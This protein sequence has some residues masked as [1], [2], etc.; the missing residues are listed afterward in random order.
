MVAIAASDILWKY[1]VTTGS[2]GNSTAG[3]QAGSLGKYISTTTITD[4][5]LNNWTGD[6]TASENAAGT[7]KYRCFFVLNNHATDAWNAPGVYISAQTASGVD[8][9][10]SVDTTGATAKAS[11]S[12]QAKTI[13][14]ETTAPSSQTFTSPT[15]SGT[16]LSLGSSLAAGQCIAVWVRLTGDNSAAVIPDSV[17]L[18]LTGTT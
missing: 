12:A 10:I 9:A 5:T 18:T 15:T 4:N 6:Y 7:Q 8:A 2:A 1:S 11:A 3:S 14:N 16:A 13:A 17:T